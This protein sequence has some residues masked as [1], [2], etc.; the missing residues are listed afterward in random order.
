M[1]CGVLVLVACHGEPD[2]T[3]ARTAF[4]SFQN[5]LRTRNEEACRRL[6]TQE[7]AA[8]LS[9]M[10]WERIA[11]QPALEVLSARVQDYGFRVQVKDP[12]DGGKVGEYVVVR[13]YGKLVVDLVASAALTAE[14]REAAASKDVLDPRPLTPA[15]IDRIRQHELATPPR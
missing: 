9:E 6:L 3:P 14:I 13:E 7:S 8:A 11:S 2:T 1:A 15:D 12:G 5:A 10:P 4:E